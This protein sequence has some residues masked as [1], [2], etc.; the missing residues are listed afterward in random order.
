MTSRRPGTRTADESSTVALGWVCGLGLLVVPWLGAG[1]LATFISLLDSEALEPERTFPWLVLAVLLAGLGGL[2]YGSV[3]VPGFRR[4]AV[5]ATAIAL[6]LL[7][8]GFVAAW[9]L[10]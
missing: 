8:G 5:P 3:R 1:I 4:G 2:A 6:V 10:A 9:V 7:I